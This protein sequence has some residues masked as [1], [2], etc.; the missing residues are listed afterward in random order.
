MG[1]VIVG[2]TVSNLVLYYDLQRSKAYQQQYFDVLNRTQKIAMLYVLKTPT[3][4]EKIIKE[5]SIMLANYSPRTKILAGATIVAGT[6]ALISL[7]ADKHAEKAIAE[8]A[9]SA[10]EATAESVS[11]VVE[12]VADTA[13]EMTDTISETTI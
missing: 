7:L 8:T 1:I 2:L 6:S 4:R 10:V 11:E 3:Y 9:Q 5:E 13:R 12:T